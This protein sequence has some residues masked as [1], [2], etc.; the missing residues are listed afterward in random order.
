MYDKKNLAIL[1]PR[2]I[3]ISQGGGL[4]V[5]AK[6]IL[7][8]CAA[9][10]R[11]SAEIISVSSAF[12][13]QH[14]VRLLSPKSWFRGV[15]VSEHYWLDVPAKKVGANFTEFEFQ[16]YMPRRP[17]TNLLNQYDLVQVVAGSPATANV[18]RNVSKPVCLFM[19]TLVRLE[20]KSILQKANFPRKVYGYLMLPIVSRIEKQALCQVDHVFAETEYTRQAILPYVDASKVSVDT[21]GVDIHQFKPIPE[22]QR[23]ND[24]ILSVGRFDDARKN[25]VLLFE[26]YAMLR[27]HWP[28]APKLILAGKT[29]PNPTAWARAKDLGIIEHIVVN[30]GASFEELVTLYQNAAV[31]VLSSNEE[32]LGIVLLEA[33]ACAT[34]VIS[35]R[36]GGPE[37]VVSEEIG[38]LTPVGDAQALAE[39][40]IWMFQNP[41]QQR[42]M[43]QA[44]RQMVESRF[45][46]EVVGQKYL[47]VY[48]KLL[49]VDIS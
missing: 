8:T 28:D 37:S 45:S 31:Y 15:Q 25:V 9:S 17:L 18:V 2:I 4:V 13:D 14:S 32:G 48:D 3:N 20:R 47:D 22:K 30:Q 26:A 6:F 49:G 5:V 33:M 39:R 21:I 1:L 44:G 16:R 41:E 23:T 38:F 7:E 19:A 36:C 12:N 11:Y 43:G 46:N 34:P 29:A 40:L 27:Q 24:Y 10:R 35:T 42:I